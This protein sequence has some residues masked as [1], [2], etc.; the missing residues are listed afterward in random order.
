[1]ELDPQVQSF[2]EL[3]DR[4]A[5]WENLSQW[6]YTAWF[7]AFA[8]G[9]LLL[10]L[11]AF[12]PRVQTAVVLPG[13]GLQ[14]LLYRLIPQRYILLHLGIVLLL[15]LCAASHQTELDHLR[16]FAADRD[17]Q[18]EALIRK[19]A[20]SKDPEAVFRAQ[21]LYMPKGNSLVYMTAGNPQLAAD[22]IW[23][24]SQQ[25]VVNS[26]RRGQKF[27]MLLRFYQT[28]LELDPH[29][30][31]AAVNGGKVLSALEQNRYAVEK[32]YI[33][34]IVKNPGKLT[35]LNEAGRLFVVPPLNP[36]LRKDYAHR[37]IGWFQAVVNKL[38]QRKASERRDKMIA[39]F[40]DLI[41]RLSVESTAYEL[42]D[43]L[44]L[45]NVKDPANSKEFREI[46]ARDWLNAR[47]LVQQTRMQAIINAYKSRKA[48]FPEDLTE[49][50]DE[51]RK[52]PVFRDFDEAGK[53]LDAF[54]F[55]FEYDPARG[56]VRSYGVVLRQAIQA[57]SIVRAIID[58][59]RA[60][61]NGQP[62][63]DLNE[64]QR[65]VRKWYADP[66]NPPSASM[67]NA[68]GMEL[69]VI[70]SPFGK[71][72]TYEADKGWIPLPPESVPAILFKNAERVM[73]EHAPDLKAH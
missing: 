47:S 73:E 57:A 24:T 53:P 5:F 49:I 16:G 67:T 64:L 48:K 26:F 37:A 23:L 41:A 28:M 1:M 6:G 11:Y 33:D 61:H 59:Y 25:Y 40:E 70:Q 44:L 38:K 42:A 20:Q 66:R 62:P 2:V 3:R 12:V 30:I 13:R 56:E 10:I 39:E 43:S 15:V 60:N 50:T 34:A 18:H 31:D 51:L 46:S 65:W 8:L 69:N 58:T 21:Y 45:K 32:F 19:I 35:L 9:A 27:D 63:A 55:H 14:R 17:K 22:Y 29:W 71:P 54:G 7:A 72:W 36:E 52:D 68:I 4:Y